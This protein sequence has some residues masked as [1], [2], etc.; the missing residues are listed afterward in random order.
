VIGRA[1]IRRLE[2]DDLVVR[3]THITERME[4]PGESETDK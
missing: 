4:M 3:R 2:I 1:R